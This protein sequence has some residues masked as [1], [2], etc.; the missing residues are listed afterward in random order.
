[1]SGLL[2]QIDG[3]VAKVIADGAYAGSPTR[4]LLATRLGEAVEVILPS[5]KTAVAHQQSALNPSARDRHIAEISTSGRMAWQKSTGYNQRSRIEI[6]MG[7]WKTV[8]APKLKSRTF[9]NQKTEAKIG[10]RVLNRMTELGRPE[11]D[12]CNTAPAKQLLM[13]S[14]MSRCSNVSD[15]LPL[16]PWLFRIRNI[17]F[18]ALNNQP[19]I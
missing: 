8:I 15:G 9:D 2:G 14:S 11:S 5:P 19:S 7:R 13:L 16:S 3:P 17:A 1:L 6:Q 12:P 10:V 18:Q 4:D